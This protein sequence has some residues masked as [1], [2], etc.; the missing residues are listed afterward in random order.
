MGD[1]TEE[2][3]NRPHPEV[4]AAQYP[5]GDRTPTNRLLKLS[6]G[7]RRKIEKVYAMDPADAPPGRRLPNENRTGMR[8]NKHDE[9]IRMVARNYLLGVQL[10]A[11][12]GN[13]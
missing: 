3:R 4:D 2:A 9:L 1:R 11:L 12:K 7:V 5:G 8:W 10:T 6:L 13:I